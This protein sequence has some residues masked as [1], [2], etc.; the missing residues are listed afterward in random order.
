[1]IAAMIAPSERGGWRTDV[2]SS[3]ILDILVRVE[4]F[5]GRPADDTSAATAGRIG[6]G[7]LAVFR[8]ISAEWSDRVE[9]LALYLLDQPAFRLAGAEIALECLCDAADRMIAHYKPLAD[10]FLRKSA[11]AR[12]RLDALMAGGSRRSDELLEAVGAFSHWRLEGMLHG[13]LAALYGGV[14]ERLGAHRE[15]LACCREAIESAVDSLERDDAADRDLDP[16]TDS[17]GLLLPESCRTVDDAADRVVASLTHPDLERID[18]AVQQALDGPE[19]ADAAP[20]GNAPASSFLRHALEKNLAEIVQDSCRSILS[21]RVDEAGAADAFL[22]ACGGADAAAAVLQAAWSAAEPV[23]S[24]AAPAPITLLEVPPGPGSAE[25]AELARSR[26][27]PAPE[28]LTGEPDA[29][30]LVREAPAIALTELPQL[31]RSAAEAFDLVSRADGH[32]PY[33]R[34]DVSWD[35]VPQS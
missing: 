13:R 1:M 3:A 32:P 22:G 11:H 30:V 16:P 5:V 28:V 27:D 4:E 35:V 24:G 7:L 34:F 21:P 18:S 10:E 31:S 33:S 26:L 19:S 23:L 8:G 6:S 25:L 29:V 2:P 9:S 12:N 15:Q 14:L 20:G 17:A